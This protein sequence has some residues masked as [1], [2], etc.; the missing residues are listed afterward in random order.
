MFILNTLI[1][2]KN[3]IFFFVVQI[4][5]R[6]Y[7]SYH[8]PAAELLISRRVLFVVIGALADSFLL[9]LSY[10]SYLS[11]KNRI[12]KIIYSFWYVYAIVI[13]II[14]SLLIINT[15]N[16]I[17]PEIMQIIFD[18]LNI[19]S[20]RG[21]LG[22][23]YYLYLTLILFSL[24]LFLF[25]IYKQVSLMPESVTNKK[26][27]IIL[28]ICFFCG[29]FNIESLYPQN[30]I[31][32]AYDLRGWVWQPALVSTYNMFYHKS[33]NVNFKHINLEDSDLSQ[34]KNI[35][36]WNNCT[37]SKERCSFDKIILI[38]V[39]SLDRNYINYYNKEIPESTTKFLNYCII[40]YL[41]MNNYFTA[42]SSTD[43][44]INALLNSRLNYY[45]DREL[46]NN[47]NWPI[48]SVLQVA[49][50]NNYNTYFIRGSSKAYG[51]HNFYYPA[52]FKMENFITA[53]DF[54]KNYGLKSKQWGIEDKYLFDEALKIL[55]E[56]KNKKMFLVINTIDTHPPYRDYD[57]ILNENKFLNA[58]NHLDN[59]L[60]EFYKNIKSNDLLKDNMLIVIT[61]DHSATHGE[62]YT[63][64][65]NFEPDRIPLIFLT[66][67]KSFYKNIDKN[68]FCSQIDFAP[69]IIDLLGWEKPNSMMGESILS[70]ESIS[71]TKYKEDIILR[72]QDYTK[73]INL[74]N[75][76]NNIICKWYYHYY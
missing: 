45:S 14:N 68:K 72:K 9:F 60:E 43:N 44:G 8:L 53:E 65:T 70:K 39:E 42:S 38:I 55:N 32:S 7:I 2:Y 35:G 5:L 61:A 48:D 19:D 6:I 16:I 4:L 63:H 76:E 18:N 12:F 1:N 34:L 73:Y 27:C 40:N 64:R 51:N 62:N 49:N 30:G 23:K 36:I 75:E 57:R 71:V 3:I 31:Y 50:Y 20:I 59:H 47:T 74:N 26:L 17:N 46:C 15:F 67:N 52:L 28:S 56:N 11:F 21:V 69:T 29:Y 10:L 22:E 66:D 24:I 54:Y 33:T 13:S 58:L 25:Y 41:S 37:L